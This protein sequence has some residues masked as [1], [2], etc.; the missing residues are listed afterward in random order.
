MD[1]WIRN[2]LIPFNLE[3]LDPD[4]SNTKTLVEQVIEKYK[5]KPDL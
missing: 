4:I 5:N 3:F 2:P 1:E